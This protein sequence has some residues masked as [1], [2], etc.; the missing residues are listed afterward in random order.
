MKRMILFSDLDGTLIDHDTY[1]FEGARPALDQVRSRGIPVIICSSKTRAEIEVYRGRMGLDTPFITENGGAI[2]IPSGLLD[3][4]GMDFVQKDPYDVVE[5]GLSYADLCTAW[6]SVRQEENFRMKGFSEMTVE[7]I[8]AHTGLPLD[9]ARLAAEREYSEPFIFSDSPDHLERL[10]HVFGEMG[11]RI[12]RGGRFYHLMGNNDKGRAVQ[13][14][15]GIY[16]KT[17]IDQPIQ[18][19]GLGDS[20]NDTPMLQHVDV[21]VVIRKKT[22]EWHRIEEL[23]PIYSDKPGPEGWAEV[24]LALL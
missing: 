9:E 4:Q 2:L 8:A 17:Y 14:L 15:T 18:T 22:G 11:L 7:E 5:L 16:A 21:P 12:T 23:N 20:D 13:I 19:V 10:E 24:V 6:E 3:L 1:D